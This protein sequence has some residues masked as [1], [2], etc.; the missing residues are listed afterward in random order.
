MKDPAGTL[1]GMGMA[2]MIGG[3]DAVPGCDKSRE[4]DPG[5]DALAAPSP[6]AGSFIFLVRF[7][8]TNLVSWRAI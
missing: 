6:A 3:E 4:D 1:S 2:S 5:T 8:M 7:V